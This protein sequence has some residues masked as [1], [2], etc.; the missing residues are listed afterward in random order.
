MSRKR[1]ILA[2][3][4]APPESL[5]NSDRV[6][7]GVEGEHEKLGNNSA[8]QVKTISADLNN[9]LCG[10][11]NAEVVSANNSLIGII[12]SNEISLKD[13]L[14]GIASSQKPT[15]HGVIG[16]SLG[17]DTILNDTRTGLVVAQEVRSDHIQTVLL[18]AGHV[19]GPVEVLADYRSI[20]IFGI[21]VGLALGFIFS[22][23]RLFRGR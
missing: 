15:L 5:I 3:T 2:V 18:I 23:F 11:V 7:A 1:P 13:S 16:V 22:L 8:D 9:S 17:Q 19:D 14:I 6:R 12:H 10:Q 21:S 20:A 4:S